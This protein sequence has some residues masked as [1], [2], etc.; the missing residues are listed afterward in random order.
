MPI[1]FCYILSSL[2]TDKKA[3]TWNCTKE[4]KILKSPLYIIFSSSTAI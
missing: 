1:I 3:V 4:D 2:E